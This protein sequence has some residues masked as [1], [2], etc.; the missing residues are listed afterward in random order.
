M[1][2]FLEGVVVTFFA[3]A[4]VRFLSVCIGCEGIKESDSDEAANAVLKS[5]R[6]F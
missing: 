1:S 6:D 3:I 5:I 4:A 2:K